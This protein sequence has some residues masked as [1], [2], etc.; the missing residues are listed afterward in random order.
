MRAPCHAAVRRRDGAVP[1][2]EA[3]AHRVRGR[4]EKLLR[5]PR[6]VGFLAATQLE[7]RLPC[8]VLQRCRLRNEVLALTAT[9]SL[10]P[11]LAL[12]G[13]H[14]GRERVLR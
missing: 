3:V 8:R 2:K 14:P 6:V 11:R 7:V 10:L 4:G 12:L 1:R 5:R 13:R 9:L